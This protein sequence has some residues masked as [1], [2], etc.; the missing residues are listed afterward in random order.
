MALKGTPT[1]LEVQD[2]HSSTATRASKFTDGR[3]QARSM[4]H[5]ER[6]FDVGSPRDQQA[7]GRENLSGGK[8]KAFDRT[9]SDMS[10]SMPLVW[11]ISNGF[12]ANQAC[13]H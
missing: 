1:A 5:G 9:R 3:R 10:H 12:L 2:T 8:H 11:S 6:A 4:H 7:A 13:P